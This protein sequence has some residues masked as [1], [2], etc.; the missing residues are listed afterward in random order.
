ME[1]FFLFDHL[2]L[3]CDELSQSAKVLLTSIFFCKR[4]KNSFVPGD[5]GEKITV[6]NH[7]LNFQ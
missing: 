7:F 5:V 6:I 1:N 2:L 4:W 3:H